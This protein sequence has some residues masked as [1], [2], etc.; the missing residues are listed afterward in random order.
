[1]KPNFYNI[2]KLPIDASQ[3]EIRSAYFEAAKKY[4]PDASQDEDSVKQFLEIQEAYDVLVNPVRRKE[5]DAS[6]PNAEREKPQ[7]NLEVLYSDLPFRSVDEEQLLYVLLELNSISTSTELDRSSIHI[8]LIIDT[9]NS[10]RG[11]RLEMVMANIRHLLQKL[12]SN[13]LVSIVAFN[14][15]AEVVV[16]P[17]EVQNRFKIESALTSL[18]PGGATEIYQGLL[19]GYEFIKEDGHRE[20]LRQLILITDGHTYGDELACLRLADEARKAGVSIN[21]LGIGDE[22]ND[23]FL[24]KLAAMSGGNAIYIRDSQTL[25]HFIEEKIRAL[26]ITCARN[27]SFYYQLSE[28]VDLTYAFRIYPEITPLEINSPL[29]LGN[30]ECGRKSS[31]ILEFK[32]NPG[33]DGGSKAQI[34]K[35]KILMDI[36]RR[37]IKTTR[38]GVDIQCDWADPGQ[39]YRP[40]Q[41]IL[42]AMSKLTLYRLQEKAK[43][44]VAAGNIQKATQRL[45]NLASHLLAQGDK[46]FAQSVLLEAEHIQRNRQY[47]KEGD[48]KIKYG[49]RSLL[50]L[51]GPQKMQDDHLS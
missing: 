38:L 43:L 26:N 6:F 47:S 4:H 41:E 36:P 28:G 15:R 48:K 29:P 25:Y 33:A 46:E 27:A 23:T 49:T 13:D 42:Q 45:H 11:Q 19:K 14:D 30:L 5:Y 8:C 2:L 7:V 51:P 10:M 37:L 31:V 44:D 1:M 39:I 50:M 3:E 9:S 40:P 34:A 18:A 35:G 24:D 16:P 22:W 17:T 20:L 21:A 12:H 32:I